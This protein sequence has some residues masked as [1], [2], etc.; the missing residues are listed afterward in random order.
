[1]VT[2]TVYSTRR[3]S[4]AEGILSGTGDQLPAGQLP[5]APVASGQ[6]ITAVLRARDLH[7]DRDLHI[8][9]AVH[10]GQQYSNHGTMG[11]VPLS[12]CACAAH[13]HMTVSVYLCGH[14]WEVW[15]HG[16]WSH[17]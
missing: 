10:E 14:V 16:S 4:D 1:M 2:S 15:S 12:R 13:E 17:A 9:T 7:R 8:C 6:W 5:V 3:L 11:I